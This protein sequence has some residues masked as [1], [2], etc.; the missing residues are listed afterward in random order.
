MEIVAHGLWAAAAAVT[1]RRSVNAPVRIGWAVWWGVFPDVLAFGPMF[2]AGLWFRLTGG[3]GSASA[4]GHVLPHVHL[5]VPLY[6]AAHSLIVFLG[7]FAITSVLARRMVFA[8][9]GWLLHILIDIPTHS[10]RYYATRFLW[11]IADIR[12]DGVA[13]WT[14]W[15]WAT[16]YGAL[17]AV[18]ILMWRKGWFAR[19]HSPDRGLQQGI[20][21]P[22][23]PADPSAPPCP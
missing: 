10:L 8:M 17:V 5:G 12:V 23:L 13:W 16:T 3:M 6:A 20:N 19:P 21:P 22:S 4:D 9:L 2:A 11:P 1:A 7:A 18:Y 14:P 15:F